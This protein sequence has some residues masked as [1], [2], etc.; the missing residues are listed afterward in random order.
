MLDECLL[1]LRDALFIEKLNQS[2]PHNEGKQR[3]KQLC[4][5]H[6]PWSRLV[7]HFSVLPLFHEHNNLGASK[8]HS[9]MGQ[10]WGQMV[11]KPANHRKE[12]YLSVK[13]ENEY[14]L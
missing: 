1:L 3:D 11:Q 9:F 2:Q 8:I 13:W 14:K 7:H 10:I 6:G 12:P 5:H 4:L